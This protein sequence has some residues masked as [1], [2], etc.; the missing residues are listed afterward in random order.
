[1]TNKKT[2][3]KTVFGQKI[4]QKN[5]SLFSIYIQ[6]QKPY[7]DPLLVTLYYALEPTGSFFFHLMSHTQ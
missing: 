5:T 1:M 4:R 3:T 6:A 7:T 2:E